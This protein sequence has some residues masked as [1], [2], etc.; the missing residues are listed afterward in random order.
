M[1]TS[2]HVQS[3]AKAIQLLDCLSQAGRPLSLQELSQRTGWAKSTVHGLLSTMREYAMIEQSAHDGKYYLGIRLFELGNMVSEG[4]DVVRVAREF[5][6]DVAYKTNQS[7]SLSTLSRGETILL[8]QIEPASAYRVVSE[9][10]TRVPAHCTSHGKVLFSYLSPSERKRILSEHGMQAF[11]PHTIVS[12]DEME[13]ECARI[14]EAGYSIEN[15]EYRIGLRSVA[16]PVRNVGGEVQY[17]IM[18]VGMFRS[19]ESVEFEAARARVMEA[20]ESVSRRLGAK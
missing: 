7:V 12:A 15:G 1:S 19:I 4:W 18:V 10:G 2:S 6:T 20:A 17:A 14:R 9:A 5:L 3:V 11:T 8:D 16:A 13:Q